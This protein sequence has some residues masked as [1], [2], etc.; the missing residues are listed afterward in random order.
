MAHYTKNDMLYDYLWVMLKGSATENNGVPDDTILSRTE[1]SE[2]LFF[3]NYFEDLNKS[4]DKAFGRQM[5]VMIHICPSALTTRLQVI[6]W[7][8][9][10]WHKFGSIS[11]L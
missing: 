6:D 5:E 8:A 9:S 3:I 2:M 10:N 1:G 11:D 4:R 7:I